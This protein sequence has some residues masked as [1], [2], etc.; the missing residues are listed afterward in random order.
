MSEEM[1]MSYPKSIEPPVV[2]SRF[3]KIKRVHTGAVHC[4]TAVGKEALVTLESCGDLIR[5][6]RTDFY[7]IDVDGKEEQSLR[8]Q[9]HR[10][11][12]RAWERKLPL[13]S[14]DEHEGRVQHERRHS[15][16]EVDKRSR[17]SLDVSVA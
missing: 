6:Y 2:P 14:S 13:F 11:P 7:I 8:H 16:P 10:I 5:S 1:E 15:P 12:Y 17:V 3:K 4:L 9:C